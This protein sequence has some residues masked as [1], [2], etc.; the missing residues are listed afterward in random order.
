M[1]GK[2][3][4]KNG[5]QGGVDDGDRKMQH[6]Y[7]GH[8]RFAADLAPPRLT[9]RRT[10]KTLRR[11]PC[12]LRSGKPQ[13]RLTGLAYK[14]EWEFTDSPFSSSAPGRSMSPSQASPSGLGGP[15]S[16]A[17]SGGLWS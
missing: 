10:G 3:D 17:H 14:C 12:A 7:L 13:H 8:P 4:M 9:R 15:E 1:Q 2:N 6:A 16:M 11:I 5:F